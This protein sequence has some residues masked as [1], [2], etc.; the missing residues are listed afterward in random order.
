[1]CVVIVNALLKIYRIHSLDVNVYMNDRSF[2]DSIINN[3]SKSKMLL[4]NMEVN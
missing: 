4:L 2:S 1:M 3:H